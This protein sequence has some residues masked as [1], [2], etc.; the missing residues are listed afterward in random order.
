MNAH[1]A[2]VPTLDLSDDITMNWAAYSEAVA[3]V[4]KS[5]RFILG[6]N[7]TAFE[8]ELASYLGV[9]HVIGCNSGTDALVLSLRALGIGPGDEVITTPFTFFA[10]AEAISLVGATP[11]FCDIERETLNVNVA[12]AAELVTERTKGIIPVHLFGLPA[13]MAAVM[14]FATAHGLAVIEDV[15][16]ALGASCSPSNSLGCCTNNPGCTG[17]K[18]GS[19]GALSA[20]SFFP[21]KN[22]GAFGDGGAVATNDDELARQVRMLANHG[23]ER[24]YENEMLGYNSRLDEIQAAILRV[25]LP[26]LDE[27]NAGRIAVATRYNELFD[28]EAGVTTPLLSNGGSA[29]V[30]HQYTLQIHGGRRDHVAQALA[31]LGISTMVYYPIPVHRLPV[32]DRPAGLCPVAEEAAQT[33]LSLPIWPTMSADIQQRV[34]TELK[35]SL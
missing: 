11:V 19:L 5:G 23:S 22:L 21:S 31:D 4:L 29:S 20:M 9:K 27:D 1:L 34:A 13:D 26:R 16:Q 25:K 6:P 18:V 32:Y 30:F 3:S 2:N 14:T 28:G 7:V 17:R 12:L 33:V 8:G 35:R 10:T 24:R 15:A